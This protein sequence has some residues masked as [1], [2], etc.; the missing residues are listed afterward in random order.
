MDPPSAPLDAH[1]YF[2]HYTTREAALEHIVPTGLI[3]LSPYRNVNDPLENQPWRLAGSMFL[4]GVDSEHQVDQAFVDATHEAVTIW[5]SAR[6]VALTRDAPEAA[7]YDEDSEVFGRGWA[8][9]RMWDQYAE[10]HSGV[11]LV[12]EKQGFE[13]AVRGSLLKREYASPYSRSVRYSHKGPASRSLSFDLAEVIERGPT[14]IRQFVED[15]HADL[16]FSKTKDWESE[17]EHRLVVTAPD[18]DYVY[19]GF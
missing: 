4:E 2:F 9:A 3:R 16:F 12:F 7:G 17:Y 13:D 14:A 1:Q 8:R 10:K 15:H 5:G 19:A 6:M 11:C 18:D